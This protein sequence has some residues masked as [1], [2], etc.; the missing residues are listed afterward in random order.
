[1]T[2]FGIDK[3]NMFGFWDVSFICS[4]YVLLINRH[5]YPASGLADATLCGLPLVYPFPS[6]L[7]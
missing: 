3:V 5:G 2:E 4:F 7:V 6:Q 1:M